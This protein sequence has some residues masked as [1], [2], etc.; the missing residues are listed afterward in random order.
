[1][2]Y[3]IG[4]EMTPRAALVDLVDEVDDVRGTP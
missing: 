2:L 4:T 1:L 3:L